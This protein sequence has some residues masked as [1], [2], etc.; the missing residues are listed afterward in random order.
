VRLDLRHADWGNFGHVEG[1]RRVTGDPSREPYDRAT[2][3]TLGPVLAGV[4]L[5]HPSARTDVRNVDANVTDGWAVE[6]WRFLVTERAR[7]LAR[8]EP[9]AATWR[10]LIVRLGDLGEEY[11]ELRGDDV[12]AF[13]E[14]VP[15]AGLLPGAPRPSAATSAG[16]PVT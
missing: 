14:S 3:A 8:H 10:A 11:V 13:L 15:G 5:D 9:F 16:V 12:D 1:I 4:G 7:T 6:A 2:I